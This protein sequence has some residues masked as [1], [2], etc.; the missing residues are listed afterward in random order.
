[1]AGLLHGRELAVEAL[2]EDPAFA[3]AV[4]VFGGVRDKKVGLTELALELW[5]QLLESISF[6]CG[7]VLVGLEGKRVV[8][9]VNHGS[10]VKAG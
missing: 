1:M 3:Q 10:S 8:L 2:H 4:G 5:Q 9:S 6:L 7:E